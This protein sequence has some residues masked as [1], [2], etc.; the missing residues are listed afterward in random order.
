MAGG[1][2]ENAECRERESDVEKNGALEEAAQNVRRIYRTET[3]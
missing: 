3:S 1:E 2:A